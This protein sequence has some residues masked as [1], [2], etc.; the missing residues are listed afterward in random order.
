MQASELGKFLENVL[1]PYHVD[2][3]KYDYN[4]ILEVKPRGINKGVTTKA[5]LQRLAQQMRSE[6]SPPRTP[7][8]ALCVGDDRSD[9]DMFHM[10]APQSRTLQQLTIPALLAAAA[11]SGASA[12]VAVPAQPPRVYTVCVGLKPSSASHY[13]HDPQEVLDVIEGLTACSEA[14]A[15]ASDPM[16]SPV[17]GAGAGAGAGDADSAADAAF[18]DDGY[19]G[20][21]TLPRVSLS[22]GGRGHSGAGPPTPMATATVAAGAAGASSLLGS[23]VADNIAAAAAAA[24]HSHSSSSTSSS[25]SRGSSSNLSG[26]L[27]GGGGGRGMGGLG[28]NLKGSSGNLSGLVAGNS[29]VGTGMGGMSSQ[30]GGAQMGNK[31]A[32]GN[33]AALAQGA[34]SGAT[35]TGSS[36]SQRQGWYMA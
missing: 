25:L 19:Y 5:I 3:V 26:L 23:L 31:G 33:L 22:M 6:P 21:S 24:S 30:M 29:S 16:S 27:N 14:A 10:L 1:A 34:G 12:R 17:G 20:V 35:G 15:S 7:F 28:A 8:F 18:D 11:T 36:S 4:R 9:E 2:V 32:Y 13:L